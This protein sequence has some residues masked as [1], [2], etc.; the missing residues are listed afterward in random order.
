MADQPEDETPEQVT[1]Y[2]II[3]TA[4][5]VIGQGT[6]TPELEEKEL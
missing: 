6:A 4:S 1:R 5:G 3:I 2:E